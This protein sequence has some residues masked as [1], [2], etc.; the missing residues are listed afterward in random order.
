[1][2]K[3]ENT[4]SGKHDQIRKY[5]QIQDNEHSSKHYACKTRIIIKL[6]SENKSNP[7]LKICMRKNL[8]N[9]NIKNNFQA[10]SE[11]SKKSLS[12]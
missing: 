8:E 2:Q 1:M 12:S 7:N 9:E 6:K 4:T 3:Y 11:K 5:F 10:K